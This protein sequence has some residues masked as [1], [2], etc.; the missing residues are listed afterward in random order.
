[1]PSRAATTTTIR[2]GDRRQTGYDQ[3]G[4]RRLEAALPTH[5]SCCT[6]ALLLKPAL[7]R[8]YI[9]AHQPIR[10]F[11]HCWVLSNLDTYTH[12]VA[13]HA[14]LVRLC[15]SQRSFCA[16]LTFAALLSRG[17]RSH[18]P[19]RRPNSSRIVGSR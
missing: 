16:R 4:R 8:R 6:S 11:D 10:S 5:R 9:P 17:L 3:S 7:F 2:Q 15:S 14:L 13:L 1:M 19:K 18:R 12:C